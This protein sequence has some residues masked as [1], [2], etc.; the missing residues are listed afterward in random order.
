MVVRQRVGRKRY[1]AFEIIS[2]GTDVTRSKLT[3]TIGKRTES[4]S[5]RF[6]FEV[7]FILR[8]RGIVRTDHRHPGALAET[9]NSFSREADG[10]E[11]RTLATSGTI[12]TLKEKYFKQGAP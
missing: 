6:P 1:I 9:L 3:R 5:E 2:S 4:L 10:F 7:M 12:R 8:G 11:L